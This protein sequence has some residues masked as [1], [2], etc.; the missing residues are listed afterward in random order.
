[1]GSTHQ[2]TKTLTQPIMNPNTNPIIGIINFSVLI[3]RNA[4]SWISSRESEW[5]DHVDRIL[6]PERLEF[7]IQLLTE[8]LLPQFDKQTLTPSAEW[9]RL[10]IVTSSLLPQKYKQ[11]LQLAAST[12]PWLEVIERTPD[13]WIAVDK[14]IEDF[15][16]GQ[17]NRAELA[18]FPFLSFRLD[19]DD[20]LSINYL[21]KCQQYTTRD[22]IGKFLTFPNGI[23]VLWAMKERRID[24]ISEVTKPFI[25]IGTAAVCEAERQTGKVISNPKSVFVGGNHY[26]IPKRFPTITDVSPNM[27]LWSHHAT[28]DTHGRFKADAFKESWSQRPKR[29]ELHNTINNFPSVEKFIFP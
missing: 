9:F 21:E 2:R 29:S 1:M 18:S 28:Q 24:N 20:F 26:D 3:K 4:G 5:T 16:R 22:N 14:I 19:D 12:R 6:N 7:R 15:T 27:F 11:A 17:M 8:G 10:A 13:E 23:K 25:A